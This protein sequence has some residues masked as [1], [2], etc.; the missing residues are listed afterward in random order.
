MNDLK[1]KIYAFIALLGG[2]ISAFMY[3][4]YRK[5]AKKNINFKINEDEYRAKEKALENAKNAEKNGGVGIASS[6][7]K[8]LDG[9]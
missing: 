1:T 2:V 5:E 6:I 7:S 3:L 9:E 4:F 8:K